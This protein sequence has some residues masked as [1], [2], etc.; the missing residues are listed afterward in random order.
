MLWFLFT[1]VEK[2][3]TVSEED[4]ASRLLHLTVKQKSSLYEEFHSENG[5]D[6]AEPELISE[7]HSSYYFCTVIP[8][9]PSMSMLNMLH[10]L[11]TLLIMIHS[12]RCIL[13]NFVLAS[14]FKYSSPPRAWLSNV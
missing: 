9:P 8:S 5:L 3:S 13:C 10:V 7:H 2:S 6:D 1:V 14:Y 12:I 4:N 11:N